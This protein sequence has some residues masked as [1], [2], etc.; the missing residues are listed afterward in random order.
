M[1]NKMPIVGEIYSPKERSGCKHQVKVTKVQ[2]PRPMMNR[3]GSE[4]KEMQG[5]HIHFQILGNDVENDLKW[6]TLDLF[7]AYFNQN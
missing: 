1:T 4:A 5:H 3:D 2:L 6:M 7:N